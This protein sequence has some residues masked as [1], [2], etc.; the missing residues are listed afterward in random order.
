[1]KKLLFILCLSFLFSCEK[2]NSDTVQVYLN[3]IESDFVLIDIPSHLRHK[4]IVGFEVKVSGNPRH[5][6]MT[7]DL[8]ENKNLNLCGIEFYTNY[9]Y[10]SKQLYYELSNEN[11]I[12]LLLKNNFEIS[13]SL[14]EVN[15][16]F[17]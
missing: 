10:I 1:M 14:I 3:P 7:I 15:L 17:I 16:F 2:E 12:Y 4:T 13:P 6:R 8:I 11:E 5:G 9:N